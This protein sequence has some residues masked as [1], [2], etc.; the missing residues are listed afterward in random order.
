MPSELSNA[1]AR[2]GTVLLVEDNPEVASASANLLEQLGYLVRW[3]PNAE[4]AL[5]EIERNSIDLVVSD[6]VMPGRMD[7]LGLA[8][9]IKE[10]RP[11]LP[12]LLATG[13]S[14]A[15]QNVRADFP[16]L[17][18]PYQMHELSRALAEILPGEA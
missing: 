11:E 1:P 17:R 6:I 4:A 3:V 16:I 2:T 8:R 7:G 5:E 15:A 13:Y 9:A 10:K 14:E 12:I 18:K